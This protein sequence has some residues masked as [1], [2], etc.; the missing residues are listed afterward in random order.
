M[1]PDVIVQVIILS[2]S[3]I[4]NNEFLVCHQVLKIMDFYY[5]IKC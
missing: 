4:K 3:S 1:Y 5:F 2:I